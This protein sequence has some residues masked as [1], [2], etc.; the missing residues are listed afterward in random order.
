MKVL[1][2]STDPS[3][4]PSYGFTYTDTVGAQGPPPSAARVTIVLCSRSLGGVTDWMVASGLALRT[5]STCSARGTGLALCAAWTV[6]R[7]L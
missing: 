6:R 1:A 3:T 4:L 7:S 2:L 5:A